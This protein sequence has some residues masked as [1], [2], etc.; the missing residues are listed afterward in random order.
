MPIIPDANAQPLVAARP[1]T[2]IAS[3][4]GG[5]EGAALAHGATQVSQAGAHAANMLMF[6]QEDIAKQKVEGKLIE[7][8]QIHNDLAAGPKGFEQAKGAKVMEPMFY[9]SYVAKHKTAVDQ[10]TTRMDKQT[11]TLF[12]SAARKQ[13]LVYEAGLLK[14]TMAE[15]EANRTTVFKQGIQIEHDTAA[16]RWYDTP[17]VEQALVNVKQKVETQLDHAGITDP[18]IREHLIKNTQGDLHAGVVEAAMNAGNINAANIYFAKNRAN[19]TA[20]QAAKID[21][22]IRPET[23]YAN[24]RILAGEIL[25]MRKARMPETDIQAKK[26]E[27]SAGYPK[28]TLD[29]L[30]T[31]DKQN[32]IALDTER[33][34]RA[35]EVLVGV[36]TGAKGSGLSDPKLRALRV[37]DPVLAAQ[38]HQQI[39]HIQKARI[40]TAGDNMQSFQVYAKA[41]ERVRSG[42]MTPEEIAATPGLTVAHAKALLTLQASTDTSAKKYRID[43]D[44]I[45]AAIPPSA[46][47]KEEKFAFK[48]VVENSLQ[49][50]QQQN[51]GK[52]PTL[53]QQKEIIATARAK[54][55][56]L[57]R[58][59]NSEKEAYALT[60]GR[61]SYPVKFGLLLPGRAPAE[62]ADAYSFA[63]GVRAEL[64]KSDRQ[65]TDAELLNLWDQS[66][67]R[68]QASGRAKLIPQ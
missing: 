15:T 55:I 39:L 61:K 7:L 40:D 9:A 11:K 50:F 4:T 41:A 10:L 3:Y 45:N 21:K 2:N 48:G 54:H 67:G 14:H 22:Q 17:T 28:G 38:T 42:E 34:Q 12:E 58:M 63:Q 27:L 59:W 66:N 51:P 23:D 65:Y 20:D 29:M 32:D 13:G 46:D 5:Q 19:M 6:Q 56:E 31:L 68:T 44:L 53:D 47:S 52:I 62:I 24:A 26:L 57:G 35:G 25:N 64:R 49:L 36:L 30:N 8:Q 18:K 33:K 16:M 43:A 1:S 60:E 37:E